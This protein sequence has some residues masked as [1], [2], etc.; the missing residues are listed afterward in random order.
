[1]L[2]LCVALLLGVVLVE[3]CVVLLLGVALLCVVLLLGVVLVELCVVLLDMS[4]Q[5]ERVSGHDLTA[6]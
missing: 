6:Q 5:A 1:M 2:L 4:E 3:L